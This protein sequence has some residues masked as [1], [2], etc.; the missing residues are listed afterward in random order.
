MAEHLLY[1]A[2]RACQC[3]CDAETPRV[4]GEADMTRAWASWYEHDLAIP[5]RWPVQA[6]DRLAPGTG[7]M[8]SAHQC[9]VSFSVCC[10]YQLNLRVGIEVH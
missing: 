7:S 6:A 9:P 1:V 10:S 2:A 8:R 4:L 3:V 5:L